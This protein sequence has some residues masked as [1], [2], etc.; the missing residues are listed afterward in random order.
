MYE[1]WKARAEKAEAEI[2]GLQ[3]DVEHEYGRRCLA[4][5][6]RDSFDQW[7]RESR[8]LLRTAEAERDELHRRHCADLDALFELDEIKVQRDRLRE[9]LRE[10]DK[11]GYIYHA[12]YCPYVDLKPRPC[13]C[14]LDAWRERVRAELEGK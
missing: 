12:G 4:E 14:G 3:G 8:A 5:K 7:N 13:T 10:A 9:L 1:S 11:E 2:A 6:E